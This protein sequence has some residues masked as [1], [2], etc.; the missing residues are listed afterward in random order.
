MRALV[1]REGPWWVGQCIERDIVVQAKTFPGVK[2]EFADIFAIYRL[3]RY[4][5]SR[6]PKPPVYAIRRSGRIIHV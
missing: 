5:L 3:L 6:H 2:K 1:F 4:P